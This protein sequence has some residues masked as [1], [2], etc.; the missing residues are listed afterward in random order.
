MTSIPRLNQQKG[1]SSSLALEIQGWLESYETKIQEIEPTSQCFVA[2]SEGLLRAVD[3]FEDEAHAFNIRDNKLQSSE[4]VR[5]HLGN[6]END[7]W[8]CR[9]M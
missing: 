4:S 8:S 5:N 6:A 2:D 1:Q 9:I 7:D 3:L